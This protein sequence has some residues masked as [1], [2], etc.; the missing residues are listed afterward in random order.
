MQDIAIIAMLLCAA[1]FLWAWLL[2]PSSLVT[3]DSFLRLEKG[4]KPSEVET[5]FGEKGEDWPV[6][7]S[8]FG[9]LH[10]ARWEGQGIAYVVFSTKTGLVDKQWQ[11]EGF[12]SPTRDK[13]AGVRAG[14][15][16]KQVRGIFAR[17]PDE[18]WRHEIAPDTEVWKDIDGYA[19]VCFEAGSVSKEFW[20]VWWP[21]FSDIRKRSSQRF[22][23]RLA[24]VFGQ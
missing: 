18:S 9:H 4:M 15:T 8:D 6:G 16:K 14:M 13:F 24:G 21:D 20:N 12:L 11:E 22:L 1:L 3:R 23:E 17:P 10:A 7:V 2:S 19:A 5:L